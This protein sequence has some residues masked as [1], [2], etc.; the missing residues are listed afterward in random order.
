MPA[1][2]SAHSHLSCRQTLRLGAGVARREVFAFDSAHDR[3][4]QARHLGDR[5]GGL[6]QFA[7][8]PDRRSD[9]GV[10]V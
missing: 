7:Q 2:S 10:V 6:A 5:G 1:R 9:L 3:L 8:V 4:R